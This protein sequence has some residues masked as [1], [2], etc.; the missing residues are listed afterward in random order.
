M[1]LIPL[2]LH[3][4]IHFSLAALIG[5]LVGRRFN[6]I[7]LGIA[8]GIIGGFFIDLDHV[9]EYFLVYGFHFDLIYFLEGRQFLSSDKI[10]IW[11]HAWE[12]LPVLL[13]LSW[14][15]RRQKAVLVILLALTAGAFVHL[16]SDCL[17]NQ[18]PPRNYS[19]IY[20]Y[21]HDFSAQELLS[22]EQ[23]QKYIRDRQYFGM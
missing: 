22:P 8:F 9:L 15:W 23:Y 17:I 16:V 19:L 6:R 18:Y 11:F 13:L 4:F 2:P 10:H 20:R 3:L 1:P 7:C 5:Y 14:F 12:Y 21:M